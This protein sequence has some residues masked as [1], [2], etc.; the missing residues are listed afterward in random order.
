MASNSVKG[1]KKITSANTMYNALDFV[2]RQK[3]SDMVETADIV[4]IVKADQNGDS[5]PGGYA[6]ATPLISQTDGFGNAIPPTTI[7]KM[8]FYR[9]QS[10]KAAIIM[11]P[12]PGDKALAVYTK[13]DSS[14]ITVGENK[15]MQPASF[16]SFDHADGIAFNGILGD[17][18]E[19]W[20]H[21]NPATGDISLSTK[22]ANIEI[23][24]R[25]EGDIVV[26]TGNGNVTIQAGENGEGDI[27]LDGKVIVTRV[28]QVQNKNS[29]SGDSGASFVGGFT[30]TGGKITSNGVTVETH[31][32]SGVDSGPDS[33]GSPNVG[34]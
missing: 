18:P 29:E 20:L 10:G 30:N 15:P 31:T 5:G 2:T 12:Q 19:I 8:V 32:H 1:Q 24:C 13:R 27:T 7:P 26:K 9:P 16:R 6:S 11:D 33:S 4:S 34:T 14:G 25:E 17:T 21:L 28:I 22:T 23:S 3:I